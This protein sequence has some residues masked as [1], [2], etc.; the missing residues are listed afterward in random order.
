MMPT[1][2]LEGIH[3]CRPRIDQQHLGEHE[4]IDASLLL[5]PSPPSPQY[6]YRLK[7]ILLYGITPDD[8]L[9]RLDRRHIENGALLPH[10]AKQSE[11]EHLDH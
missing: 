1:T 10:V 9:Q 4:I 3:H 11:H 7:L 6:L 8:V 2:I 5:L